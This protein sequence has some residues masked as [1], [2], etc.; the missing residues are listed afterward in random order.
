MSNIKIIGVGGGGISILNRI[1]ESG[2]SGVDF[3]A[4]DFDVKALERSKAPFRLELKTLYKS[5]DFPEHG[6]PFRIRT[7]G[8]TLMEEKGLKEAIGSPDV[9]IIVAGLGRATGSGASPVIAGLSKEAG[10]LTV[11]LVTRPFSFEGT[12][13]RNN[14]DDAIKA[15]SSEN[16]FCTMSI[17]Q[18]HS[19]GQIIKYSS[20]CSATLLVVPCDQILRI[21][22]NKN[23]NTAE[24]FDF[25][26]NALAQAVRHIMDF[27]K[28]GFSTEMGIQGQ[29]IEDVEK[30]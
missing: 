29:K 1:I 17:P 18:G 26:D 24:A 5:L 11:V 2:L 16:F 14:A 8:S 9:V 25:I 27:L 22:V 23:L 12:T 19:K 7:T 15:L 28:T 30:E 6:I 20:C 13:C 3:L 4:F 10:A 21:N